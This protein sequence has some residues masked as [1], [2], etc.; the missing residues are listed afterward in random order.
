MFLFWH[1]WFFFF[2][3]L[4]SSVLC[5]VTLGWP[6]DMLSY[7]LVHFLC[8]EN[9]LYNF[10]RFELT[11]MCICVCFIAFKLQ[12]FSSVEFFFLSL[13]LH[14]FCCCVNY[15]HLHSASFHW[16]GILRFFFWSIVDLQC[17]VNLQCCV[18]ISAVQQMTPFIHIHSFKNC[19]GLWFIIA[20]CA[21]Q[22]DH[23]YQF[24]VWW[25]SVSVSL[26]LFCK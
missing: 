7:C 20:P 1:E 18:L 23:V 9:Q 11:L 21:I 2:A 16:N 12:L 10:Q 19:F 13:L 6:L 26:F 3:S 24:Y 5:D 17:C 8:A 22:L 25:I 14:E 15:H 4:V